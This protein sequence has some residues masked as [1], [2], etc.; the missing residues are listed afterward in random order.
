MGSWNNKRPTASR[1]TSLY[2]LYSK[3]C[4]LTWHERLVWLPAAVAPARGATTLHTQI[5][6]K[7]SGIPCGC[8]VPTR[9]SRYPS[10]KD[11][12]SSSTSFSTSPA[13]K[14]EMLPRICSSSAEATS[15]F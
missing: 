13:L 15:L 12:S 4:E 8:Q 9:P 11:S 5:G 3:V 7:C 2:R 1:L 14:E 6:S 10:S